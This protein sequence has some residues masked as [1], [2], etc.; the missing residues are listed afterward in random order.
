MKTAFLFG[1]LNRGGLETLM[2]D[3]CQNL[4]QSDFEA[5]GIYRKGGVLENDFIHSG[6]PF[7][8]VTTGK[9]IFNYLRRLRKEIKISNVTI[10][11][12]QQP[13]DALYAKLATIGLSVKV[14]LT[15][16]GFDFEERSRLVHFII[17]RT[18]QNIFVSEYQ[19][20]YYTR[21]YQL[22]PEKQSVVYNGI[23]FNK[24][25]NPTNLDHPNGI[26]KELKINPSTCL[27]G[28]V[29]NFNNV[30]DQFTVCQFLKALNEKDIDFQFLFIGK[31]ID[32]YAEKYDSCV[33]Y[34]KE[35]GLERNVSFLGVR[36]D[37]PQILNQ[38]DAFIYS[39]A[40]DTFG[41]AVVEAIAVGIP[42]F[43]N[44]WAVMQEITEDGKLATLYKTK[45]FNDL[46]GKFMVFLQNKEKYQEQAIENARKVREKYSIE[47]YIENLTSLYQSL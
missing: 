33:R 12:A 3:V 32:E 29:G 11:H 45:D 24:F 40:H 46:L 26:R 1:S 17:K 8:K 30:R 2:L 39:T 18:N 7:T 35:N 19:Q 37:V 22:K 44:D 31:R 25:Y 20:G 5:I 38:L 15:F 6:V 28:M 13:I 9:N 43:V 27:L 4:K 34:C 42:V 16:H 36:N 23:N 14:L 10:I 21:K 41:I 47:K